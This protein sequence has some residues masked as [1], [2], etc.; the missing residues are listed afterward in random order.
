[1]SDASTKPARKR[2]LRIIGWTY[3][4]LWAVTALFGL[5]DVD[6][7][8]D[9]EFAL[10]THGFGEGK[11]PEILPVMRIPFSTELR[12]PRA[13]P[14]YVPDKPWRSR[15]N[16]IAIAP[17]V[18]IDEVACQYGPLAGLSAHRLVFLVFWIHGVGW[19]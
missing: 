17:F 10:G 7:K 11:R 8:F 9:L 16:G 3:G 5:P 15:S 1:M 14:W 4:T 19:D 2:Y 6:R 18:V 12:D 13:T